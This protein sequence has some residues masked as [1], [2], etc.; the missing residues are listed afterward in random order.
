MTYRTHECELLT[1]KLRVLLVK[2]GL[3]LKIPEL[4]VKKQVRFDHIENIAALTRHRQAIS[5]SITNA[6]VLVR[7]IEFVT[8]FSFEAKT[9]LLSSMT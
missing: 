8:S 9:V 7:V 4:V 2:T 1:A 5:T 6:L 3:L